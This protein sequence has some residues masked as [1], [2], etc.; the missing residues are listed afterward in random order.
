MRRNQYYFTFKLFPTLATLLL[1]PIL[2]GLGFWQLHRAYL[3]HYLAA[4]YEARSH[5]KPLSMIP[6]KVNPTLQF[7]PVLLKGKYDN[8]H[9]FLLD[10]RIYHHQVG[11]EVLTPLQLTDYHILIL[12]NRGWI[13][14]GESRHS[15]PI[16]K[17]I[18]GL[19]FI[20]GRLKIPSQKELVLNKME[21]NPGQWPRV[22]QKIDLSSL[23]DALGKPL[24]PYIVLLAPKT[25][26]GFIREWKLTTLSPTQHIAYAIQWFTFALLLLVI[27]I[28]VNVR[29]K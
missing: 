14:Q 12:V 20:R 3:K 2:M 11:Y 28:V 4:D 27:Y 6:T 23:K 9:Q 19:Q 26:N 18:T 24:S 15:L 21:E 25:P 29:K 22:V 5:L 7:Y 17:P 8:K 1:L 13:P 16:L 10:N